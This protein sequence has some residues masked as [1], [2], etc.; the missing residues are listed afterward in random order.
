L[1][2]SISKDT[3]QWQTVRR[4]LKLTALPFLQ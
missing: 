4:N 1:T 3:Q 2:V